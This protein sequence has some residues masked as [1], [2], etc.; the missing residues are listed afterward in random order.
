[1]CPPVFPSPRVG[2]PICH[3]G[4]ASE[5][6][7]QHRP[8]LHAPSC[9]DPPSHAILR[10]G[11][12]CRAVWACSWRLVQ[13][14]RDMSATCGSGGDLHREEGR[15]S[16]HLGILFRSCCLLVEQL[17]WPLPARRETNSC[18]VTSVRPLGPLGH[19]KALSLLGT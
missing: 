12:S 6:S 1:V 13:G 11:A 10:V 3:Q 17:A 5:G 15:Q 19:T 4:M 9:T 2:P 18:H 14:D 16:S 7:S 8:E